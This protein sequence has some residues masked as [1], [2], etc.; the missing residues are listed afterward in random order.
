MQDL[1]KDTERYDAIEN[2]IKDLMKYYGLNE[3]HINRLHKELTDKVRIWVVPNVIFENIMEFKKE[4]LPLLELLKDCEGSELRLKGT[5][6]N[7]QS[8]RPKGSIHEITIRNK[9]LVKDLSSFVS[10]WAE[11]KF[12][13]LFNCN[14]ISLDNC[15][16]IRA[17]D[18]QFRFANSFTANGLLG[19]RA[20]QI[21]FQ[22]DYEINCELELDWNKTKLYSFVYDIMRLCKRINGK[23]IV[24]D[25]YSGSVGRDK[26]K[27]VDNWVRA[28]EKVFSSFFSKNV[29]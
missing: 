12:S 15:K 7:S 28:Y 24:E 9:D 19:M 11:N 18:Y 22:L 21:I 27:A 2:S 17:N 13:Q 3:D 23:C 16:D 4:V 1:D 26:L 10:S 8:V 29:F 25:G 14:I 6:T 5:I 20:Y